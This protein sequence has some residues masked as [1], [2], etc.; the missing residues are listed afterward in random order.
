[1]HPK[2]VAALGAAISCGAVCAQSNVT[3]YGRLDLGLRYTSHAN[4]AGDSRKSVDPGSLSGSRLGFRGTEDL[5]GG[6][7][8]LFTLEQGIN[9][10]LGT[11]AQSGRG[12]GRQSWVALQ[13]SFITATLGRQY[14]PIYVIEAYN[15]P[16]GPYNLLEPGFIYDNYTGGTRWDNALKLESQ[17]AGFTVGGMF[18]AGEGTAGHK[19]GLSASYA[20]G[21]FSVN[22]AWQQTRNL[23]GRK[24]HKAWTLGG[25]WDIAP[26]KLF[27]SYLDHDSETNAQSNKV[28]STGV[29]VAVTPLLDLVLGY[30]RDTQ[31]SP[32]HKK[33]LVA[34]MANYKLS[35]RTNVYV[36]ADRGEQSA[37]YANAFDAGYAYPKGINDRSTLTTGIRHV[38]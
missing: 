23:A 24:D 5:G 16:F 8:A 17:F 27:L 30:Y 12:F 7:K 9:P 29:N 26:V 34:A 33:Q 14:S 38:F 10:D 32:R 31:T 37:G 36:Q 22:A 20:G 6:M 35:K 25:T 1:M 4:S 13:T 21:P 19:Q 18:A 28:W 11:L 15:E 2:Y 3:I